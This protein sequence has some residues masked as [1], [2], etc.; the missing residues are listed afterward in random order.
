MVVVRCEE[1]EVHGSREGEVCRY[2]SQEKFDV[3]PYGCDAIDPR[4]VGCLDS[5]R[6]C[7]SD[8]EAS[9]TVLC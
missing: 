4:E 2:D 7:S 5:K 9:G 8:S 6:C 1:V 3:T